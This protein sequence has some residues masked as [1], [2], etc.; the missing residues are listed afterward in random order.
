MLLEDGKDVLEEI[1]LLVARGC[2][3]IIAIDDER[4]LRLLVRLV[5]DGHAA[6]FAERRIGQHDVILW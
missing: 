6:L 1:E 4:F 5:D 2:P 3:E